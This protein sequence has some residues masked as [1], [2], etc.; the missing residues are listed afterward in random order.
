MSS[1]FLINNELVFCSESDV[2]WVAGYK[3]PLDKRHLPGPAGRCLLLLLSRHGQT[4]SLNE[5]HSTVWGEQNQIVTNNTVYQ[6]ISYLRKSF[7]DFGV[8]TTIIETRTRKGW[9]I[10][11]SI[12]VASIQSESYET[13][14]HEDEIVTN[15][16]SS[17]LKFINV[18]LVFILFFLLCYFSYTYITD[19]DYY[20]TFNLKSY[21]EIQSIDECH[22]LRNSSNLNNQIYVD[23]IKN[24]NLRCEGFK[25]WYVT[26]YVKNGPA[27]ILECNKRLGT[28][29]VKTDCISLYFRGESLNVF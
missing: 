25:W 23:L 9:S 18:A 2:Y 6:N 16:H 29:L 26:T 14:G 28:T 15:S 22:V 27:S 8:N 20:E 4:V 5:L 3:T 19:G 24:S 1:N 13:S 21:H 17:G 12:D 11:L 7:K 10:P